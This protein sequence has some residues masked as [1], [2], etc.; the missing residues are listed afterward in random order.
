MHI[1]V[2]SIPH[3]TIYVAEGLN[4]ITPDEL[5]EA[6]ASLPQWRRELALNFKFQ[7][8]RI[9]CAF[10]YLLLCRALR[11]SYGITEQPLFE[12]GEHGKPTLL[13][14]QASPTPLIH[15]NLS[16]C[17]TAIACVVS[18]IP[19]GIDVERMG[20]YRESLARHVFNDQEFAEVTTSPDPQ[21]PFTRLW[22]QKEAIVKLTGRGIDDN[23][24]ELL[25][26]YN[27]VLLHTEEHV[28]Q[29]YVLTVAVWNE[30]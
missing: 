1:H 14:T 30:E 13:F 29:D 2:S 9:E 8:G 17:K 7:Q 27:N 15:F 12:I 18:E 20:R 22:T 10:S 5:S 24:Q 23:L 11:E 16:H 26:K 6:L 28:Q 4:T 3:A 25:F 21:I 19:V